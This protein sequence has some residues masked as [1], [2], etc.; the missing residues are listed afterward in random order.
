M[1]ILSIR[2]FLSDNSSGGV[3]HQDSESGSGYFSVLPKVI[4]PH[5]RMINLDMCLGWVKINQMVKHWLWRRQWH[6]TPVLLP[7]KSHGRRSLVGC[8]PW[9]HE[10]SDTT[11]LSLFTFMHWR[12]K[13][14]PTPVFLPGE[15]Q[16]QGSLV[17]CRL[18]T[19]SDT[20]EAT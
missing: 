16:G 12:R 6:P 8:S 4:C 2:S 11:S 18:C 17:G 20:T 10:E 14:Q 19:E 13:W 5:S 3:G 1:L 9:G 7:G 15:S